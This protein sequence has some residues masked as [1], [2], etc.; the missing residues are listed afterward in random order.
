MI[1]SFSEL[2]YDGLT[3]ILLLYIVNVFIEM[4]VKKK[5]VVHNNG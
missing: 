2:A 5:E 1:R 4:N 3:D